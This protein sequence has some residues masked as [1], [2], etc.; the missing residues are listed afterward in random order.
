MYD[1]NSWHT[2]RSRSFAPRETPGI[3]LNMAATIVLRSCFFTRS[4]RFKSDSFKLFCRNASYCAAKRNMR[5]ICGFLESRRLLFQNNKTGFV[6]PVQ[7]GI[8]ISFSY[9]HYFLFLDVDG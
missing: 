4:T 9:G 1:K 7:S 3:I 2:R 6:G 5:S 8:K